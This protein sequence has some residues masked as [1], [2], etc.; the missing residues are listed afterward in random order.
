MWN[1]KEVRS[2]RSSVPKGKWRVIQVDMFDGDNSVIG[3][4]DSKEKAIDIA[5]SERK[6]VLAKQLGSKSLIDRFY[7]YDEQGNFVH[8]GTD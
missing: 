3:N 7:V 5:N 2:I 6:R 1:E 4:Y 8:E